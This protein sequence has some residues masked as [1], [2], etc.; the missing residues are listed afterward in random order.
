AVVSRDQDAVS[1]MT[2]DGESSGAEASVN[3]F[4]NQEGINT[5][6]RSNAESNG[7]TAF[8][9]EATGQTEDGTQL[10]FYLYAIEYEG[11][12]YR[13]LNYTTVEKYGTYASSFDGITRGFRELTDSGILNIKPVRLQTVKVN[14]TGTFQS[15]LPG[16]LESFSITVSPEDLAIMNQV[17]IDEQINADTW[18]KLPSQ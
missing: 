4:L 9:A 7:L 6:R 3:E 17:G 12:I 18:L 8:R 11:S 16:N 15:F 5:E 13:F 10:K 2:L 14:Q 1:I